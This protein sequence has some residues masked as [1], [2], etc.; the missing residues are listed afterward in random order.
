MLILSVWCWEIGSRAEMDNESLKASLREY[1][2]QVNT[3]HFQSSK[4][5]QAEFFATFWQKYVFFVA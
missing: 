3:R 5:I 4:F 1:K 2:E